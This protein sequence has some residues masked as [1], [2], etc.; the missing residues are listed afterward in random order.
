MLN[1]S[2]FHSWYKLRVWLKWQWEY[3]SYLSPERKKGEQR[4][5]KMG[6]EGLIHYKVPSWLISNYQ[7]SMPPYSQVNLYP[8]HLSLFFLCFG[9]TA[10]TWVKP[11]VFLLNIA[12]TLLRIQFVNP[13][14]SILSNTARIIFLNAKVLQP[15]GS[16]SSD[17]AQNTTVASDGLFWLGPHL[18]WPT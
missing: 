15:C 4:G 6:S 3:M 11:L 8:L 13:P 18:I 14:P 7:G 9:L 5:W 2:C 10:V 12:I 17:K 1:T 16:L